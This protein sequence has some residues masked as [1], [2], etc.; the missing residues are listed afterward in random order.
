MKPAAAFAAG[1][2]TGAAVI[3]AVGAFYLR[4]WELGRTGSGS[5]GR[6][7]LES[8]IQLL[9]QEQTR[10]Q[11]EEAR[12]KQTI[13]ELQAEL[14]TR[15]VVDTRRQMRLARREAIVPDPAVEPWMVEAVAKGDLEALPRLEQAALQNNLLALDALALLAERDSGEALA[16]VWS[17]A[18][19]NDAGRARGTF[20]LAATLEV[21]AHSEDL[22]LTIFTATPANPQLREAALAGI[23]MPDFSTALRQGANFP[24]PPHL[25]PDY[26]QRLRVV[27][28]W[29]ATVTDQQV[30][31]EIDRVRA[32]LAQ[33][34]AAERGA[35]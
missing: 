25:H 5:V 30:L 29:R 2:W 22:L 3:A 9:Q 32:R 13:A 14:E 4:V 18:G 8:R 7:K 19:L 21:N 27:E 28:S 11:A 26:V 15:M 16:R 31:A 23:E 34:A 1:L 12:L 20:L 10:A 6:E 17:A 35:E 24:V 33:H